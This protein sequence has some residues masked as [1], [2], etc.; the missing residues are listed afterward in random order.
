MLERPFPKGRIRVYES[1]P[2]FVRAALGA[3]EMFDEN[4]SS[5]RVDTKRDGGWHGG[6]WDTAQTVGVTGDVEQARKLRAGI[7]K[8]A[9]RIMGTVPRLDPVYREEGGIWIDVSRYLNG[10][11]EAW[12]DMVSMGEERRA[13]QASIVFS[14]GANC[15]VSADAY[16][17]AATM[18]GG[19]ILG[20]KA[21]GLAVSLHVCYK[22]VAY[23][24]DTDIM[25]V[26]MTDSGGF[27]VARLAATTRTWFFRRLVFSWWETQDAKFRE[28]H[29]VSKYGGYGKSVP[30]QEDEAKLVTGYKNPVLLNMEDIA[31]WDTKQIQD[32][33]LGTLKQKEGVR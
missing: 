19:A 8:E 13:R 6:T 5:R 1:Y 32:A 4:R 2:E 23:G 7:V 9:N 33:I 30:M 14:A 3:S 31:R 16:E 11:P 12:G 21:M 22:N 28:V 25:A 15:D 18:I 29:G 20:L 26:N 24:A 27:D 17:N 10:E